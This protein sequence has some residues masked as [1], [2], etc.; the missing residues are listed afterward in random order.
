VVHALLDVPSLKRVFVMSR[1][2]SGDRRIAELAGKS[3]GRLHALDLDETLEASISAAVA[4]ASAETEQLDLI[5]NCA[6]LLHD[7]APRSS[8]SALSTDSNQPTTGNSSP[9]MPSIYP[10]NTPR[11]RNWKI[12]WR[13]RLPWPRV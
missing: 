2:A 3:G 10:G 9:G 4:A 6:G 1:H 5:I 8:C 12:D 7:G 11:C 13:R